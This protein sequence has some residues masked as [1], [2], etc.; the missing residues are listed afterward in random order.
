MVNF[1]K[2]C[3]T[4]VFLALYIISTC[5]EKYKRIDISTARD[6]LLNVDDEYGGTIYVGAKKTKYP[7]DLN[8]T[9]LVQANKLPTSQQY[10]DFKSYVGFKFVRFDV[11]DK[12]PWS[13]TCGDYVEIFEQKL[14]SR[15]LTASEYNTGLCSDLYVAKTDDYDYFTENS[16]VALVRF[17]S[18]IAVEGTGFE[19]AFTSFYKSTG[20]SCYSEGSEFFCNN[21]NC[22]AQVLRC[23]KLDN[24]GDN[25][26]EANCVYDDAALDFFKEV[27]ELILD[28]YALV[29]AILSFSCM[30]FSVI[31][32]F[33]V[34]VICQDES[35]RLRQRKKKQ[36]IIVGADGK[37]IINPNL[38]APVYRKNPGL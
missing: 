18:D 8:S 25:S 15:A 33:C 12:W 9:I 29:I 7:K 6:R 30:I 21:G 26:D 20:S 16:D 3:C 19:L 32:A 5:A 22:I 34:R 37:K 28:N 13:G 1:R 27:L 24:C 38:K 35:K 10:S 4:L 2:D 11:P 17:I 23:D 14:E 31:L 36:N